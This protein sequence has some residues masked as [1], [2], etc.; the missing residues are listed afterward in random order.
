MNRTKRA[1]NYY[2][3]LFL[4]WKTQLRI[5]QDLKMQK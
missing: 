1:Y 3:T 2:D 4:N 5:T